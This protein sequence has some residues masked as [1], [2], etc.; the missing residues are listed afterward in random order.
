MRS[1]RKTRHKD[2]SDG[3]G[4]AYQ[5]IV[6]LRPIVHKLSLPLIIS[7]VYSSR[8]GFLIRA[9]SRAEN[10]STALRHRQLGIEA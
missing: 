2:A 9:I 6:I 7:A 4:H 8:E 1:G 10:G 5:P 3:F